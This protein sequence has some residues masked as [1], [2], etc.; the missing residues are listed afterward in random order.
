MIG[1]MFKSLFG[2]TGESGKPASRAVTVTYEDCTIIAEPTQAGG[3][4]Q[5]SGRI[6]KQVGEVTKSHTFIRAD[7]LPDE[8]SAAN[9]MIRKAKL[10]IDQQGDQ[11]FD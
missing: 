5:I 9:E 2:G 1:K 10:M 7:T 11:L 3:Q 8:E 6:E 4:W